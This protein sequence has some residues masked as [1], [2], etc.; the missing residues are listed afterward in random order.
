Y[1]NGEPGEFIKMMQNYGVELC[2]YGHLHGNDCQ[3][4]LCGDYFGLKLA[5]VSCDCLGFIP[6]LLWDTEDF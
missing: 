5:N 2:I 4:A 6:Q 3:N 1:R